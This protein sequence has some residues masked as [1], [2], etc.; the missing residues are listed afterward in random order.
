M[1]SIFSS[2]N[3]REA[4]EK[5]IQSDRQIFSPKLIHRSARNLLGRVNFRMIL[6]FE[7]RLFSSETK[8]RNGV[9]RFE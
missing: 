9:Q 4:I 1:S 6:L 5:E 3:E 8:T 2:L 7:L